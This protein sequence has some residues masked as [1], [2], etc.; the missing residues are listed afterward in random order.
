MRLHRAFALDGYELAFGLFLFISPWLFAY[1]SEQARIDIWGTGGLIATIS[2]AAIVTFS[3]WEQ[4]LNLALG[5]WLVISPW[6]L[7]FMHT[8][9]MHVSILVGAM[10]AFMAALELWLAHFE[11][12]Y[13]SERAK[14]IMGSKS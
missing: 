9:A 6:A 10:V 8:K 13:G 14:Q 12:D 2:M 5:I 1:A 3:N 7:G 11:P 4:W